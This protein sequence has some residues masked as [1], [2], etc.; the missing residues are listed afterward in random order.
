VNS[1]D[2]STVAS[3]VN[4]LDRRRVLLTT[5]A[6]CGGEIFQVQSLGNS[7]ENIRCDRDNIRGSERADAAA[8]SPIINMK[9]PASELM[10]GVDKFC[11]DEWEGLLQ[12]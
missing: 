3:V 8:K 5:R 9:F 4:K 12:G 6:T 1:H 7:R 2:A 10:A 11:L